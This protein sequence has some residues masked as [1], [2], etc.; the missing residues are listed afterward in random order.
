MVS[1]LA[2]A[3]VAMIGAVFALKGGVPGLPKDASVHRRGS[4]TD[5]GSA[6]K[7]RERLPR[8]TTPAVSVLKDNAKPAT[9]QGRQFRRAAGRS[10]RPG[11][12]PALRLPPANPLASRRPAPTPPPAHRLQRRLRQPSIRRSSPPGR[13][14]TPPPWR[15]NSPIRSRCGPFR[16]GRTE[17]RLRRQ[18]AARRDAAATP[19]PLERSRRSRRAKP[20]AEAPTSD[21][22]AGRAAVN[23]Q[24]RIAD[25]AFAEVV[26]PCRGRE[27]RH[28]RAGRERTDAERAGASPARAPSR[29]S[30][31]EEAQAG[32]SR[33]GGDRNGGHAARRR[34][35][36]RLPATA[37]G[38]WAVQL[39]APRSEAEA[40]SDAARL[41]GKYG[42]DLNGSAIGVHKAVVNGETIY[43]LRVVGLSKADAAALC[44][45][46]KG[47]GRRLLHRQVSEPTRSFLPATARS[48]ICRRPSSAAARASRST[49]RNARSFVAKTRGA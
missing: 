6:A 20:R 7:R 33:G 2:L 5:Q 11:A 4:G 18:A 19:A 31:R 38:G 17:R 36:T 27:D 10:E 48:P 41:N 8:P 49:R 16:C 39:A 40:K 13:C 35:S 44:A 30:R 25:Q 47:R 3:G 46:L 37:S 12:R 26:R 29:R 32:A 42:A 28:D 1:A 14:A 9:G 21:A 43:R 34:P 15:R 24:T 22:A 45:R 23:S